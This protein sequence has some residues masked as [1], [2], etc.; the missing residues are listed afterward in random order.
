[1]ASNAPMEIASAIQSASIK[2]HPSPTHDI[3]P[4][5]VAS[6]KQPVHLSS[7]PDPDAASDVAEDEIPL[8]VLNPVPRRRTFGPMPDMRFEQS[9]MQSI[10]KAEGWKGV[11]WITLRD[12][13][14]MC[15]GQGLVYT[16]LLCGWKHWNREAQFSGHSVGARL[17]RW[18]WGVNDWKLPTPKKGGLKN[19][20][21]AKNVTEYYEDQFSNAGAD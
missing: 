10:E 14:L 15:F 13:V 9:Y 2:R 18:W 12:Q 11:L 8:S 6:E 20:N 3:N 1:M 4:S 5:T 7:Y 16:L 17:R 21:L 19:T